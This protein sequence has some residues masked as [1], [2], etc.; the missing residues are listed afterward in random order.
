MSRRIVLLFCFRN[1]LVA[2]IRATF[3]LR[4]FIFIFFKYRKFTAYLRPYARIAKPNIDCSTQVAVVVWTLSFGFFQR[5]VDGPGTTIRN[6]YRPL[7]VRD[8][9]LSQLI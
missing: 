3:W 4:K 5:S 2:N 7:W 6:R 1:Q 8:V 9:I